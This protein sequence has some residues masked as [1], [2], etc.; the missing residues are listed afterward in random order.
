MTHLSE[1]RIAEI[2]EHG[3]RLS[4]FSIG[5][6]FWMS[7]VRW[8]CTGIGTQLVIAIKLNHEDDPSSYEG[9][10]DAVVES[11]IDAH[12][13][14]ACSLRRDEGNSQCFTDEEAARIR[15]SG[16]VVTSKTSPPRQEPTEAEIADP[17]ALQRIKPED[18]NF[19]D[20][21]KRTDSSSFRRI[22]DYGGIENYIRIRAEE[23]RAKRA[24]KAAAEQEDAT[25]HKM[26]EKKFTFADTFKVDDYEEEIHQLLVLV[27]GFMETE[28]KEDWA[29]SCLVS[30]E[31]QLRDFIV[32]FGDPDP[33]QTRQQLKELGEKLGFPVE[34]RDYMVAIAAR[35][36]QLGEQM[37]ITN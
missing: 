9:S 21:P 35:M 2:R 36:R 11:A 7:V 30:D 33:E 32:R 10:P 3:M 26:T 27:A 8:R 37:Q 24:A 18:I 22:R 12:D 4:D 13:L 14:K 20:I 25:P 17:E 29:N 31:S 19:S 34:R 5:L 6:E 1:E 15:T 23:K 28:D 16:V